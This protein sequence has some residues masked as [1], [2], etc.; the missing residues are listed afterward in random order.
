MLPQL[1]NF[2]R[3]PHRSQR[4]LIKTMLLVWLLRV[5]L[6]ILPF[7]MVRRAAIYLGQN[8]VDAAPT[9]WPSPNQIA[10]AVTFTSQFVPQAT[11]LTQA[12]VAQV[13]LGRY[14]HPATLRIGVIRSK[15]GQ[16][17]AH[18]WVESDGIVVIGGTEAQLARYAEL[19]AFEGK[20]L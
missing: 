11:C 19:P 16:F 10:E 8:S 6:W 3:L 15:A 14:G 13:L 4:F 5:G 2:L 1:S 12:L 18:A 20:G 17:Q 7:R 9:G